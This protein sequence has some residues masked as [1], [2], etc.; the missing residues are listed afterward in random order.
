MATTLRTDPETKATHLV[1][2]SGYG[3]A[4]D[5]A[6]A[7]ASGFELHLTKP[8]GVDEIQRVLADLA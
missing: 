8:V 4:E 3:Q 5:R 1:A 7:E 6:R 2:L